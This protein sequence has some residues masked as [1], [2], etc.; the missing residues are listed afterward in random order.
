MKVKV[1]VLDSSAIPNKIEQ[2]AYV[3]YALG[4]YEHGHDVEHWL[5]AERE[6]LAQTSASS[7]EPRAEKT[8]RKSAAV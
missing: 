8:K 7:V 3:L 2:R 5:Q 4:G 6:V 1:P